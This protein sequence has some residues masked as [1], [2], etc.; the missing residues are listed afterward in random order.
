MR[1]LVVSDTHGHI[2]PLASALKRE[3]DGVDLVI[4]CGDS[5]MDMERVTDIPLKPY[6]AVAGNSG[7]NR[8]DAKIALT[9]ELEGK[10]LLVCH[11]HSFDV[12]S[13]IERL[14][15]TAIA[16]E[17]DAVLFGHTHI[18]F[19]KR[20]KNILF[21]NPGSLGLPKMSISPTY[22]ILTIKNSGISGEFFS[23]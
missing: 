18:S 1:I 8:H 17:C 4:H 22:A 3:M 21:L 15:Y 19:M 2:P 9:L 13:G 10:R 12:K 6:F 11:G 20:Y 23:L 5:G 16:S 7:L 14:K